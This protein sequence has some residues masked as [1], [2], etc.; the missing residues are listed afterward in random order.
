MSDEP[1]QL[2]AEEM[3][4]AARPGGLRDRLA[5]AALT[6]LLSQTTTYPNSDHQDIA[7]AAW[8]I[9]DAMLAKREKQQ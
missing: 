2:N 8:A 3:A 5:T 6:G 4:G 7:E 9:A 1:R